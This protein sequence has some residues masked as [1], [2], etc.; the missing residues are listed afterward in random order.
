MG[1]ALSGSMQKDT[2]MQ[3][4][5][6]EPVQKLPIEPPQSANQVKESKMA[7]VPKHNVQPNIVPLEP[8]FEESD[9]IPDFD[10]LNAICGIEEEKEKKM[11][12]VHG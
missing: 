3:N 5:L 11:S 9:D 2:K 7:L 4:A 6:P 8:N 1:K 12:Q 10:L